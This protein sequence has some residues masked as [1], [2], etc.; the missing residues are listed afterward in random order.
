MLMLVMS[1]MHRL[2]VASIELQNALIILAFNLSFVTLTC[3]LFSVL[4]ICHTFT[5]QVP[6]SLLS[7]SA[8]DAFTTVTM[9]YPQ[10][11]H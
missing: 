5:S 7:A 8:N 4:T 1:L 10:A 6:L 9:H 3:I 11:L 2:V